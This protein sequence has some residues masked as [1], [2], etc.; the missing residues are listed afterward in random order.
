M[1]AVPKSVVK[2]FEVY[3][4]D[5]GRT[6][7]SRM[8][9]HD[10]QTGRSWLTEV[11]EKT[12]ANGDVLRIETVTQLEDMDSDERALYELRLDKELAAELAAMPAL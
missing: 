8:L 11:H 9:S 12:G 7:I 6:G 10:F 2:N 5:K 3:R 4:R 1:S